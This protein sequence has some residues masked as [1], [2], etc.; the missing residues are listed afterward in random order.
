MLSDTPD[1]TRRAQLE[2]A[3]RTYFDACNEAD[4]AKF[5]RVLADDV[6]HYFPPG[7]GGPYRGKQ[8]VADLWIKFVQEKGSQWTID[9]LVCDGH[10]VAIEWTHWK[11][12]IG[13][14]I[15]G[16]EWYEFNAAGLITQIRAYYASPRDVSTPANELE[17]FP[18]AER[19]FALQARTQPPAQ[20]E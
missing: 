5:Y 13:E 4:R 3:V 1:Q 15:R 20:V 17:G 6:V 16:A 7:V 14:H 11:T 10:E 19:G 12:R 18:Y 2:Q 8:A 9:R